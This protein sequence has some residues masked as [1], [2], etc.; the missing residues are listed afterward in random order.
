MCLGTDALHWQIEKS[1]H[2]LRYPECPKNVLKDN[3]I[4]ATIMEILRFANTV[5]HGGSRSTTADVVVDGILI[6]KDTM[7]FG[8]FAEILK[9]DHWEQAE[10][11]NPS[12]FLDEKGSIIED[13][14]L[15]P[16]SIGKRVCPGQAL[17]SVQ[18]VCMVLLVAIV[19]H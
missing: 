3:M 6:P 4:Q 11:F 13:E 14:H 15:I 5:P 18:R 9:G 19:S 1:C 2:T 7:I 17:A 10:C 8:V 12:R 16:F